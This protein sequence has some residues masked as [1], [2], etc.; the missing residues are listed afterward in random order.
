MVPNNKTLLTLT[1]LLFFFSLDISRSA[2]GFMP[3]DSML[4][5]TLKENERIIYLSEHRL[6][7]TTGIGHLLFLSRASGYFILFNGKEYGPYESIGFR[8][9]AASLLDWAVSQGGKWYQLILDKGVLLGPYDNVVD[10][11]RSYEYGEVN[12]GTEYS[13]DHY[14]FRALK[15][16]EWF[17]IVD[18]KSY[19]PYTKEPGNGMPHFNHTGGTIRAYLQDYDYDSKTATYKSKGDSV[20]LGKFPETPFR[21]TGKV[22]YKNNQ[23]IKEKI[24]Y[25]EEDIDYK[26]YLTI[27]ADHIVS[28]NGN[29]IEGCPPAM[30][31][32]YG[33]YYSPKPSF[34]YQTGNAI[35]LHKVGDSD[36]YYLTKQ[37]ISLGPL[38]DVEKASLC[39]S[40]DANHYAYSK[41]TQ[42]VVNGKVVHEKGFSLVHNQAK[43]SFS[44]LSV[45]GRN[46][47]LHTLKP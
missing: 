29:K 43:D 35:V 16:K 13:G 17:T 15:G 2:P 18:G 5:Y 1:I 24:S 3:A 38:N 25:L 20:V 26:N 47:Y 40:H 14:G 11:Y 39:F 8:E 32:S 7:V 45:K 19:G 44:W 30:E 9:S 10:V 21:L 42:I 36:Y 4:V 46:I 22:L 34:I 28:V 31:T 12:R 41:G 6:L 27:D 33:Y 37:K 23:A